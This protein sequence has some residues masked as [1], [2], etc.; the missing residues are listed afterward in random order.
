MGC[1]VP[2]D[3]PSDSI[4][5]KVFIVHVNNFQFLKKNSDWGLYIGSVHEV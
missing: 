1:Y 3:E 2:A 4:K 5:G